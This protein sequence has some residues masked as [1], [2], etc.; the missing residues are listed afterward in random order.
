MGN[1][2]ENAQ[3]KMHY[4]KKTVPYIVGGRR[5]IGDSKGFVLNNETPWV[6]VQEQ[7]LRDFKLANKRSILEGL[8]V[9]TTEPSLDWETTNTYTDED[10]DALFKKGVAQVRKTLPE[11]TS[12]STV[13]RMLDRAKAQRRSEQMIDVIEERLEEIDH[14][15]V[16]LKDVER[17]LDA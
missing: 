8:I 4:Y 12:I 2:M 7:H 9:E 15:R 11:I 14:E 13:A 5:Y 10:I 1:D 6:G 3:Q 16:E 17:A